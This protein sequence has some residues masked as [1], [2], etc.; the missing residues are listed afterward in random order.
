MTD[1]FCYSMKAVND[2]YQQSW[3]QTRIRA[4]L[5]RLARLNDVG[6]VLEKH[7]VGL[8]SPRALIT[9]KKAMTALAQFNR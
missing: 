2:T 7:F 1:V 4:S 6:F 3:C 5:S 9:S 8:T